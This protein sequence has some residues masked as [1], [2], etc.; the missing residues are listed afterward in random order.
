L[1]KVIYC[2]PANLTYIQSTS[3]KMLG[4]MKLMLKSRLPEEICGANDKEPACQ[5]RRH[6]RCGFNHWIKTIPWRRTWQPTPVLLPGKLN[7][8]RSLAGYSPW[9]Q[10]E[11]EMTERQ[12]EN[13][14]CL[15]HRVVWD[16]MAQSW[17]DIMCIL[18]DWIDCVSNQA[19]HLH[20]HKRYL[21]FSFLM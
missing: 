18:S 20:R 13:I 3:S 2:H 21:N 4:W 17:L 5:C 15:G 19:E 14:W 11:S 1:G 6:K 16:K 8:Q 9:G 12:T 7:E 10:K